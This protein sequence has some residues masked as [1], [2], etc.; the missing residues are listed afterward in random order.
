MGCLMLLCMTNPTPTKGFERLGNVLRRIA[1]RL[2]AQ[3]DSTEGKTAD[4]PT[5]DGT[6]ANRGEENQGASGAGRSGTRPGDFDGFAGADTD[7]AE[8]QS[9]T[10]TD[11]LST[12]RK[13]CFCPR[14][15]PYSTAPRRY[16][17]L[18]PPTTVLAF[19]RRP[20]VG[21]AVGGDWPAAVI[22]GEWGRERDSGIQMEV[23]GK[24]VHAGTAARPKAPALHGRA[25]GHL[26]DSA[27]NCANTRLAA[28]RSI[29]DVN[30]LPSLTCCSAC[31]HVVWSRLP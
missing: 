3:R 16:A 12:C 30:A 9:G 24:G 29:G 21:P 1:C 2:E 7:N 31:K 27:P 8:G 17:L 11:A 13:S 26:M 25:A 20:K 5:L 15:T 4:A 23:A 19:D 6:P 14:Q 18:S 10:V 28:W 22:A